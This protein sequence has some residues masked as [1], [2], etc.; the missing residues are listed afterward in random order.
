MDNVRRWRITMCR[1]TIPTFIQ[2]LLAREW[3]DCPEI[4]LNASHQHC[5]KEHPA[6]ILPLLACKAT[7]EEDPT[8]VVPFAAAC[9][10]SSLAAKIF[11][12]LEDRDSDVALYRKMGQAQALNVGTALIFLAQIA[13]LRLQDS[14]GDRTLLNI[15]F[16]FNRT[17]LRMC[18]GQHLD[19]LSQDYG[20]SLECYWHI[21]ASKSGRFFAL[22][23]QG[24]AAL[25]T[26]AVRQIELFAEFGHNL[27][28]LIQLNDDFRDVWT[29]SGRSD[30]ASKRNNLP[31]IY[32]LTVKHPQR[33]R[34]E[35][36]LFKA[37]DDQKA[38]EEMRRILSKIGAPQ[39]MIAVAEM[40][41][42]GARSA[43][44]EAVKPGHSA[45]RELSLLLDRVLPLPALKPKTEQKQFCEV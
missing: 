13:L 6:V 35:R 34:L 24:G 31:I 2:E 25:G 17:L 19:L 16:D 41:R 12:D 29:S 18:T 45:R 32:G 14:I 1:E 11:D 33:D 43:L 15:C 26:D 10:L 36:L 40:F 27:G 39:Y 9:A 30:L 8:T 4:V 23:A 21:A 44:E 42:E 7:T 5:A 37:N 3:P 28:M 22:A 38:G 20:L